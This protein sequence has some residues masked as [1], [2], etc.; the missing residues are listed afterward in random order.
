MK[1]KTLL[2]LSLLL[3]A[4][5]PSFSQS[6]YWEVVQDTL[7]NAETDTIVMVEPVRFAGAYSLQA[8]VKDAI[9]GTPNVTVVL[10]ESNDRPRYNDTDYVPT[11]TLPA[12]T[13]DGEIGRTVGTFYGLT[14]RLLVK[15]SGTQSTIYRIVL[16]IK[17]E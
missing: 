15:G 14:P 12:L 5:A 3:L 4:V 11:D 8:T 1:C 17:R 16:L 10:E 13:S 9:S 2:L 7:T 6:Y